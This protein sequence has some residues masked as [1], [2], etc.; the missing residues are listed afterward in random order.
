MADGDEIWP[1]ER[2][3]RGISTVSRHDVLPFVFVVIL[4]DDAQISS[5]KIS[6]LKYPFTLK[7]GDYIIEP[8]E[9]RF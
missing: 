1:A 4:K 8:R 7:N 6:L 3:V 5:I 2:F 9:H